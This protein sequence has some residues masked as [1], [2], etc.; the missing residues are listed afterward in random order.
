YRYT[1]PCENAAYNGYDLSGAWYCPGPAGLGN[2]TRMAPYAGV[3]PLRRVRDHYVVERLHQWCNSDL[4]DFLLYASR[5]IYSDT[6][7]H[8]ERRYF[9]RA[10]SGGN[11]RRSYRR[12][13][14]K[15]DGA[16]LPPRRDHRPDSRGLDS[17]ARTASWFIRNRIGFRLECQYERG[18][19]IRACVVV[20]PKI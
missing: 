3:E 11:C 10:S 14:G 16:P 4:R 20:R 18:V 9:L 17:N 2:T 1:L 7:V 12:I 19:F 6:S 5:R 15:C 8:N 13:L